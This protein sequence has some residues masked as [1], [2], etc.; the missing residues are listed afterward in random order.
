M[1]K[2]N[3]KNSQVIIDRRIITFIN[4]RLATP[5]SASGRECIIF[6]P[7]ESHTLTV[8]VNQVINPKNTN[9]HESTTKKIGPSL[10]SCAK[11]RHYYSPSSLKSELA[12]TSHL[13]QNNI[14]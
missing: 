6:L 5:H 11:Q 12:H 13:F 14:L 4:T 7:K 9:T 2:N 1:I 3:D 8:F 10:A